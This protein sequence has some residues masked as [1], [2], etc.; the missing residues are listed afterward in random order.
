MKIYTILKMTQEVYEELLM[1][2]YVRWCMS[3][4]VV[5]ITTEL[6]QIIA[7][8]AINAYYI[9]EYDKLEQEFINTL[10]GYE[11]IKLTAKEAREL[12]SKCTGKVFMLNPKPLTESAKK[13][14]IYNDVTAN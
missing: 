9:L 8:K 2:K 7:N 4:C 1:E 6:Q 13:T 14:N 10:Q 11:G 3:L 12:Y 5:N